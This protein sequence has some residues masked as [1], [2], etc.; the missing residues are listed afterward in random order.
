M[1]VQLSPRENQSFFFEDLG[2]LPTVNIEVALGPDEVVGAGDLL[3]DGELGSD[4]L[5]DLLGRDQPRACKPF[6][7]GC[8][9]GEEATQ[10]R[11]SK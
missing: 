2:G 4:A 5:T 11:R 10:M 3:F 9:A 8:T 6:H 1:W 7:L